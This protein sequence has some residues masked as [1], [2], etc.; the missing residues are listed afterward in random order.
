MTLPEEQCTFSAVYQLPLE[1]CPWWFVPDIT[2]ASYRKFH[3][4]WCLCKLSRTSV[5]ALCGKGNGET[6][7]KKKGW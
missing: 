2:D 1:R 5:P 4:Y 3:L 7:F 6:I